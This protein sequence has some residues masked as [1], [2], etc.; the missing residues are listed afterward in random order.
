MIF[1]ILL[2]E[3][4]AQ[5]SLSFDGLIEPSEVVGVSSQVFGTLEEVAV[6]RGDRVEKGQVIAR[7]NSKIE[8]A[9][10]D[11]AISRME[12]GKRKVLRNEELYRKKLIPIHDKDEMETE[13]RRY[14]PHVVLPAPC[15]GLH[16]RPSGPRRYRW[17]PSIQRPFG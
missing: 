7:L 9:A 13:L 8:K 12:F 4:A 1:F 14:M 3:A 5:Q 16:T 15:H 17:I 10:V 6:E 11:L 2:A